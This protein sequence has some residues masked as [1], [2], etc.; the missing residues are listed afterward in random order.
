MALPQV[1][2][3][4]ASEFLAQHF[5][6]SVTGVV[7]L[8]GG[9]WSRAF[10][11]RLEDAPLVVRFGA[12]REDFEADR[13]AMSFAGPNLPVPRVLEIGEAFGGYYAISERCFGSFLE[14]L[15]EPTTHQILPAV[16][17]ALDALRALPIREPAN[18][19][20]WLRN[21]LVDRPGGRVSGWRSELA[22]SPDAELT[23][24]EGGQVMESLLPACPQ[25]GHVL[26]LDLI[27]RNVLVNVKDGE[28]AAIFDWGC[29]TRG[30]FL[31]E[32]AWFSFW[33]SW[34]P[35]LAAV[36]WRQTVVDHYRALALHVP[37]FDERLRCYEL[38]I[39]LHHL[40]YNAFVGGREEDIALLVRRLRH[41]M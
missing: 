30:D 29:M 39:G 17:R 27:N 19:H 31:Y 24:V 18:W 26:H 20:G 25:L 40:A 38:H 23:F 4:E 16:L 15:D 3:A 14:E 34:H 1:S 12:H 5:D 9:A 35:G 37:N 21:A 22:R 2:A 28:I 10:G 8:A 11:F 6:G 41:L 36:D 13:Q 32:V 7:G 33:S